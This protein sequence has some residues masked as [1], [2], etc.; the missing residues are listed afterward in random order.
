MEIIKAALIHVQPVMN[1]LSSCNGNL[2]NRG[3]YQ[4][5]N[6]Y[7]NIEEV[8]KDQAD[9]SLYIA[10]RSGLSVGAVCLNAQQESAYQQVAWQ[11]TEPS[12]VI[13]RL[14]V[15]P[16]LQGQGIGASILNFAESHARTVGYASIRLDVYSGNLDA[17]NFYKKRGYRLAGEVFFS[18]RELP[19][20]CM[21]KNNLQIRDIE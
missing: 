11:F 4:W 2:R 7:P 3:I 20:F 1:L 15:T 17:V 13:H 12:L 8:I 10:T 18:R 16:T 9:G 21:E 19:F 5:D 6:Q 14:C